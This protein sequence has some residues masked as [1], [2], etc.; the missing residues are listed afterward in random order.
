MFLKLAKIAEKFWTVDSDTEKALFA[1]EK[2]F[3][4]LQKSFGNF[5]LSGNE[6]LFV[7]LVK[8]QAKE[9]S[10]EAKV[11]YNGIDDLIQMHVC[12]KAGAVTLASEKLIECYKKVN[13]YLQAET[14][15]SLLEQAFYPVLVGQVSKAYIPLT[16][17]N[18]MFDYAAYPQQVAGEEEKKNAPGEAYNKEEDEEYGEYDDEGNDVEYDYEDDDTDYRMEINEIKARKQ[19]KESA[20]QESNKKIALYEYTP[21]ETVL[22]EFANPGS[23]SATLIKILTL[24]E[25][26]VADMAGEHFSENGLKA[27]FNMVMSLCVNLTTMKTTTD[28]KMLNLISSIFNHLAESPL[29]KYFDVICFSF[30]DYTNMSEI[31]NLWS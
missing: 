12:W 16:M 26:L 31:T 9:S 19:E 1:A 14:C 28:L 24:C 2:R 8:T 4:L 30:F 23:S 5:L 21:A 6:A 15:V 29:S 3:T 17:V 20:A 7:D 11:I 13:S 25:S 10:G 22:Y 27:V 18:R